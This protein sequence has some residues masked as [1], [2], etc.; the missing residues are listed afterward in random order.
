MKQDDHPTEITDGV[1]LSTD[2]TK[3]DFG[4]PRECIV[5]MFGGDDVPAVVVNARLTEAAS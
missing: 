2:F 5:I 1:R 4:R 3:S